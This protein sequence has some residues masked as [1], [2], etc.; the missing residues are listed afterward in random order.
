[1]FVQDCISKSTFVL[2]YENRWSE[3]DTSV[4]LISIYFQVS[5]FAVNPADSFEIPKFHEMNCSQTT[6]FA[7]TSVLSKKQYVALH[8]KLSC[9]C[10]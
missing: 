6:S 9:Q 4:K 5:Q 10:Q 2:T 3:G 1:M 7:R 8:I